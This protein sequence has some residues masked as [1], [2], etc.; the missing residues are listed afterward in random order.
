MTDATAETSISPLPSQPQL[1]L[2]DPIDVADPWQYELVESYQLLATF[3][4]GKSQM[5]LHD[6]LQHKASESMHSH[7]ELVKGLVYGI[8]TNPND[9]GMF[10][11]Y[12]NI[13]SRDGFA[14]TLSRLQLV[15]TSH[16]FARIRPEVCTQLFWILNELINAH[17]L[18]QIVLSLTRQV[19]SGDIS[20]GNVK[21]CW[22]ML[23]FLQKHYDW[24]VQFPVLI[25]T[26]AYMF[27]RLAL[28]HS[29]IPDLRLQESEFVVRLFRERFSECSMVGRDL[30]RMLQDIARIPVVT[31]L[32]TDILKQPQSISP[33]FTGID[34]LLYTPT[35]RMFLANRITYDMEH[36]LLFILE[37]LPV[38]MYSRNLMWFV[39]QYLSTPEAETLFSDLIRYIVCVFHPSNAVLA[40]NI[41]PRYVFLGGLLRFIRSQVVAAN[42]KL[43][44]FYDWLFYNPQSDNIM[45]IEPGV[46]IIAQ[47]V[48]KYA[49]MTA[50]FIEFLA[51]V[52]DAY[53]PAQAPAIRQA[54][55]TAMQDAVD[56]GVVSSLMPIYE[57]PRIEVS[58]RQNLY[59]LFP[60]LVPPVVVPPTVSDEPAKADD[61]ELHITPPSS[62]EISSNPVQQ[63]QPITPAIPIALDPVSR[64]FQ[65]ELVNSTESDIYT[66]GLPE[67][68]ALQADTDATKLSLEQAL[69]DAG[70]LPSFVDQAQSAEPDIAQ[71]SNLASEIVD[72]CAQS[73]TPI[74]AAAR[75]LSVMFCESLEM[76][77][78]ETNAELKATGEDNDALEHDVLHHVINA[79]AKYTDHSS[80]QKIYSLLVHLTEHKLDVGFRWLLFSVVDKQQ[81][82]L[83]TQYVDQYATGTLS[84][85]LVRDLSTMQERF[86]GLFYTVLPQ[87]YAAFADA[88]VGCHGIVKSV[89]ALIDQPQVYRLN[90]LILRGT[91]QL[92]GYQAASIAAIIG[93][94]LDCNAFEQVCFWQLLTAALDASQIALVARY[95]LLSKQLDPSSNSEA[96]TGLRILL[97][98]TPP[99]AELLG[100]L[101][102]Y[103]ADNA[104]ERV[105]LCGSILSCWNDG[106]WPL[107]SELAA[108]P[109]Q[110]H[111]VKSLIS[112][113]V[114]RFAVSA[115]T[116]AILPPSKRSRASSDDDSDDMPTIRGQRRRI[117]RQTTTQSSNHSSPLL[118]SSDSD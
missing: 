58:I 57:H 34:Q 42:A 38:N 116:N 88:F 54:V 16:K 1:F 7:S 25:A 60:Q 61:T 65:D 36:R 70:E 48:D 6:A 105:D 4:A 72:I 11:R 104:D 73:D 43:A 2:L 18:D 32:W 19:R 94:A 45:N 75:I 22:L 41:V 20:H 44:L 39:Q 66:G 50:S 87:I 86:P 82:W 67:D 69:R 111:T 113:W 55:G 107:L 114:E 95:L 85:A 79:A 89:L 110:Q 5:E 91:L 26:A 77:D 3:I 9:A 21:L 115:D 33:R 51:F 8:L 46:L 112:H 78:I 29:R 96:A 101:L 92:T 14:Y 103:Y 90:T 68:V 109:M 74:P 100:I 76:E 118:S 106:L 80:A 49:F 13:V 71:I 27:G 15:V 93:M 40:S 31:D 52:S 81:P 35:P 24:M 99:T 28:D 97:Q 98:T 83:Y 37:Q 12:L 30:V 63:P 17:G 84:A 47:S 62:P 59:Y 64:M 102:K 10:F 56:K 108:D 23:Q 53:S 117:S